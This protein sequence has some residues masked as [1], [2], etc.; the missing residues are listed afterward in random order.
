M[1]RRT[2]DALGET[3]TSELLEDLERVLQDVANG[4]EAPT[5]REVES[6][7]ERIDQQDLVF[8]LRVVGAEMRRRQEPGSPTY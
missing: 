7:R 1:Y 5:P 2:A 3:A 6:W 8:R 4:S